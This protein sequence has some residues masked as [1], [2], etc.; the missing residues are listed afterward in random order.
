MTEMLLWQE[1]ESVADTT[2]EERHLQ[3]V[4]DLRWPDTPEVH[5]IARVANT[6]RDLMIARKIVDRHVGLL[7]SVQR[8]VQIQARE[9]IK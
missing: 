8:E 6:Q 9:L 7:S 3:I 4:D 1:A 2:A 5:E